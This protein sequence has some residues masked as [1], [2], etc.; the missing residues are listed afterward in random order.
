MKIGVLFWVG[1]ED[2]TVANND[3]NANANDGPKTKT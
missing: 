3:A 1:D 2:A